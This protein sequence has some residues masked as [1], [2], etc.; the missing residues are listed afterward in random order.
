MEELLLDSSFPPVTE[1][2]D[3]SRDQVK[4]YNDAI[5]AFKSSTSDAVTKP[6]KKTRSRNGCFSCKKLKIKC[7][8]GQPICE[9]CSHTGRECVYPV[10][11]VKAPRRKRA[12]KSKD[13]QEKEK[14][15]P[16]SD[17]AP[18]YIEEIFS[19][20]LPIIPVYTDFMDLQ[21]STSSQKINS[22]T[23]QL[24]VTSFEL[25]LLKFFLDFGASFFTFNVHE[26]A[27]IFW[28]TEVPKLWC[29]SDIVKSSIYAISSVRLLA[30]YELDKIENVTIEDEMGATDVLGKK[31]AVNLFRE[32]QKYLKN[33]IDL[34]DQFTLMI[35][36]AEYLPELLGHIAIAKTILV[37]AKGVL[38]KSFGIDAS[39][40][41]V[42]GLYDLL[43]FTRD[44]FNVL[45]SNISYLAGTKYECM[46][47]PQEKKVTKVD[48]ELLFINY[49]RNYI[50]FGMC[51]SDEL[52]ADFNDV[53]SRIEI[54]V[55]RCLVFYYPV[56]LFRALIDFS[57]NDAFTEA[58]ISKQHAAM[59]IMFYFSS[60][61]SVLDFKLFKAS[62]V[63]DEFVDIYRDHSFE[64][65]DGKF[66]DEMDQNFYDC[67][68]ARRK[69]ELPY[70]LDLL[71]KIGR[72]VEDFKT[73]RLE[74]L[75]DDNPNYF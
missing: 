61:C 53:I 67:V 20:E 64:L 22:M 4:N 11:K 29:S 1:F 49:L 2:P 5:K 6:G 56:P 21:L 47:V 18:S 66:E 25:R 7:N 28:A 15:P 51:D 33:T 19:S 36:D 37:A 52:Q 13:V 48:S 38:P 42:C 30:N 16:S 10:K 34:L 60:L 40:S 17:S 65:F 71:R 55:H 12:R 70:G 14:S 8:E 69:S 62:G 31:S 26:D 72:P 68:V 9:Y 73:G 27:Y 44:T 59:K 3:I 46:F 43:F 63:W 58:L 75:A 57:V 39:S 23:I 74:L 45:A 32:S 41:P 35:G 24:G 50:A 54:G